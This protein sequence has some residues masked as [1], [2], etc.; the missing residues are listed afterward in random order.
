MGEKPVTS[1]ILNGLPSYSLVSFAFVIKPKS[2]TYRYRGWNL[3][4]QFTLP[5]EP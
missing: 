2:F 3:V 5:W 4:P 1:T